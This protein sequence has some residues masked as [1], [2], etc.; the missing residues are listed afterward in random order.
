MCNF[1]PQFQRAMNQKKAYLSPSLTVVQFRVEKG[2]ATSG[3][4]LTE[5]IDMFFSANGSEHETESFST[6]GSWTQGDNENFWTD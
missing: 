4:Q 3:G 6:H 1:A 5:S 2:Y